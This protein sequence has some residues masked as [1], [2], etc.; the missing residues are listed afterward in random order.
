MALYHSAHRRGF[1]FSKEEIRDI[2]KAYAA[3][4]FAFA[5]LLL[6]GAGFWS[7][8][9]LELALGLFISAVTVGMGFVLHELGHKFMAQRYGCHAV[10]RSFDSLFIIA[11]VSAFF[12]FI[13]AVP[14]AVFISGSVTEERRGRIAAAGPAVNILLSLLFVSLLLLVRSPGLRPLLLNGAW[15]NAYFGFFNMIPFGSFDGLKVLTWNRKAFYALFGLGLSL[16]FL[17]QML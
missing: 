12:G 10:F 14:G 5:I 7:A 1:S 11:I 2:L 4:T 8:S 15:L 9:P 16:L 17:T 13:F 6:G 3:I